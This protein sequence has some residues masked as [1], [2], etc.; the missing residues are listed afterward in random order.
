[1]KELKCDEFTIDRAWWLRGTGHG[2]LLQPFT[3]KMCC[4]G[5]YSLAC[6]VKPDDIAGLGTPQELSH[7]S[8]IRGILEEDEGSVR[9]TKT[10]DDLVTAN[11]ITGLDDGRREATITELFAKIGVQVNFTGA[12]EE[13]A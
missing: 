3:G 10:C 6:G 5:F 7:E 12:H 9:D 4:L 1:M 8:T 13:K 2:I 11:D